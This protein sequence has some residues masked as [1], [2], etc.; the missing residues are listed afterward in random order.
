M[1]T[2]AISLALMLL[3]APA[4]CR[5]CAPFACTV[6]AVCGSG[7]VCLKEGMSLEGR[8]VSWE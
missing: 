1:K 3:P 5:M 6:N 8:C 4:V 2:L 7:C